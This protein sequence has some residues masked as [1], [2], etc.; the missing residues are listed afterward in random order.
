M[1]ATDA[2]TQIEPGPIFFIM[3]ESFRGSVETWLTQREVIFTQRAM[4]FTLEKTWVH[5]NYIKSKR[6]VKQHYL[7]VNK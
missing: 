4:V 7:L 2:K 1:L 5:N 3:E 6:L